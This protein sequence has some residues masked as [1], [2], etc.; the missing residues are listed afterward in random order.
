MSAFA[1][2]SAHRLT[3]SM[4]RVLFS[5]PG[6]SFRL[7]GYVDGVHG[8]F[9]DGWV[10]DAASP[11][12]ILT[13]AIYDGATQLGVAEAGLFRAD[14]DAAGVGSHAFRF[15]LPAG[16][17]DGGVHSIWVR[18]QNSEV[19]LPGS[20]C[21][22]ST[23]RLNT[24]NAVPAVDQD[25]P[26]ALRA[27]TDVL[28]AQ[29][30]L[31]QALLDRFLLVPA[32][33]PLAIAAPPV[34][35]ADPLLPAVFARPAGQHDFIVFAIIDWHFRVQRPQHL[36]RCLAAMGNRV[37]YISI[38]FD[39]LTADGPFFTIA[40]EP[41]D[42]VF[43]ITLRCRPPRPVVYTGFDDP[44]QLEELAA[45]A[46]A[47]V[48][49]LELRSPVCI[50]Q[51]PSWYPIARSIPGATV[52][53]DCLDHLAGFS[54]VAPRV[55]ELEQT[56]IGEADGVVVTSDFLGEIVGKQRPFT[57]IR[58]GVDVKYFAER[59][60]G[61]HE[62]AGRPVIGYY[63]AIS[64]WFDMDLVV[65]CARRHPKWHF[66]LIGAI[67]C[68]DISEISKLPNV[69]LL[70]EKPYHELTRYLYSF[71]VCL[72]PFKI[73]DLTRATNPVKI[74]EYLC[75]GK[76]V[77]ATDMPE[78]RRLPPGMV[79]V[80]S[81]PAEFEKAIAANLRRKDPALIRRRQLWAGRHSWTARARKLADVVVQYYPPLSVIVLCYNNLDFTIACLESLLAFSDYPDMEIICVDN[82]STDGTPDYLTE[83]ASEHDAV[84]YI[85]NDTNLGYAAGNNAGIRVARGEYIVLLNND[86]YVTK[87]WARDLIR[88]MQQDLTIGMTGPLTNMAGNE[89]KVGISYANMT[90]MAEASAIFTAGHRRQLYPIETLAFFCVAI[91]RPV[92]DAV[93]LLD[94]EYT[95]GYFEDDDY[96][97]RV[98]EA[99]YKL[100][101]CDDVFIHHHHSAS[102][103]QLNETAK[104]AL[105]RR[106][107][108]IYEKRWGRWEPHTYRQEPGFGEG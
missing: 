31:M 61:I 40:G 64:E 69:E 92:I 9:V 37:F 62:P 108:R 39:E 45:A 29:T 93:G 38:Q 67:D 52:I 41:A 44:G 75:A 57:T 11:E 86:T 96:C 98:Q 34:P 8:R 103:S 80:A 49:T 12:S 81:T 13:V 48:N 10:F 58:N 30:R 107:R 14:L 42:G 60:T 43:E 95:I 56:L 25:I 76:P 85:R 94:E 106:N 54:G 89:Q 66:V 24:A 28:T 47:M 23:S 17:F 35:W 3:E 79:S 36:S 87:G 78:L 55:V 97:R 65:H 90:E 18:L 22:L 83:A 70:G 102:F 19:A 2:G 27:L 21:R 71:D 33:L 91:R 4:A 16:I 6:A 82:G 26:R 84:R 74:Y 53:F 20:P 77:V 105:M 73:V 63:G 7:C 101:V 32:A 46:R 50:V 51:L 104:T 72:I 59:P 68:C 100:M 1:N 99:G 5:P 88:P 15:E